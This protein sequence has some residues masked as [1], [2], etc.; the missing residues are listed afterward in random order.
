MTKE[1]KNLILEMS[2]GIVF[3]NTILGILAVVICSVRDQRI[4][5]IFLGLLAGGIS[6]VLMLLHM[7]VITKRAMDCGDE[8]YANKTTMVHAIG[9]KAVYIAVL[10]LVLFRLPQVN[11]LAMVVGTMG[12]KTGAYLQPIVHRLGGWRLYRSEEGG[13]DQSSI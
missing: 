1:T 6:A 4:M 3:H 9:R 8:G 2:A 11:P 10:A 13:L 5:P 7:A 12:L